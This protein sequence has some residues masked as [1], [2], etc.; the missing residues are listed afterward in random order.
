VDFEHTELCADCNPVSC[1][2]NGERIYAGTWRDLLIL[3][4]EKFIVTRPDY[5]KDLSFRSLRRDGSRNFLLTEKPKYAARQIST[6]HWVYLNLSIPGIVDLIGRICQ[7]CGLNFND[8]EITYTP[9]SNG[10]NNDNNIERE[11]NSGSS[12][13]AQMNI[14]T[15]FR[16]WLTEQH[17]DWSPNTVAVYCSDAYYLY[18]N[19]R[20]ITLAEALNAD[21][22]EQRAF[23]AIE[24]YF[25]DNPAMINNP[26]GSAS[27]YLHSLQML[28]MFLT[29]YYPELLKGGVVSS[30]GNVPES[31]INVL[32]ENYANGFRFDATTVRLLSDK[33]SV[34]VDMKLQS[35]LKH[36]M[37]RRNDDVYFLP[38]TVADAETR[39]EIADFANNWLD[40]Y[41]CFEISELYRLFAE[42]LNRRC[43]DNPDNFEAF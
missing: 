18:N 33:A 16:E 37:F 9:K 11:C 25:T 4:V 10:R 31:V 21:D 13:Y 12:V 1:A 32:A 23:A 36:I 43:I 38:D 41:G 19:D 30:D 42:S 29:K 28:K 34:G 35:T 26:F 6:G 27:G 14:R 5:V 39:K 8:I 3:L 17:R 22:G 20:G 7:Y 24:R 15:A 40:D 2:V